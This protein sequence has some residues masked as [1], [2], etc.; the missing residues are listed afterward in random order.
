MSDDSTDRH[1]VV[2]MQRVA[3][4]D[5][6]ESTRESLR[7]LLLGVDFVWL[8][9]ECAR[10][11]YFF[12]V[13]ATSLPDLAIVALD[14]DKHKALQMIGQLSVEH[15]KLPIL[16][17]SHDH[18]ALL[19]SLQKGAKYF[20]THP[21]ALEDMLAALR[22]ALGEHGNGAEAA[23]GHAVA[24]KAA[25]RRSSPSSVPAAASAPRPWPST[26]AR[27]SPPTR[28]TQRRP[29]RPRPRPRRRRHR[30][31]SE[32]PRTSASPTWRGTSSGST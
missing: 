22:R 8:E 32:R 20:L 28:N 1:W 16:T 24:D 11:E 4:V 3:I 31:R 30:P 17:I 15:P 19:Q 12:D 14:A 26:S 25:R 7:T 23:S 6:T 2:A 29:D 10:Y 9:A 5:P 18:Q 13:I 27:R 21:V